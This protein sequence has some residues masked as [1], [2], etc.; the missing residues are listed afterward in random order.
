[1]KLSQM[2]KNLKEARCAYV[3]RRWGGL[4]EHI[5]KSVEDIWKYLLLINSGGAVALLSLMGAKNSLSPFHYA[6]YVLGLLILGVV[7]VGAAKASNYYRIYYLF[8]KWKQDVNQFYS[9]SICWD[10]LVNKDESRSKYFYL[11]DVFGW[12]SFL[13]F[14]GALAVAWANFPS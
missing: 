9:D 7:L 2:D 10:E 11:A 1:M 4:V 5:N 13:C 3:E 14:A 8:S 12:I 6:N